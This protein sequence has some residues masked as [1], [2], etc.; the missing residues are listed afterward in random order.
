MGFEDN[1]GGTFEFPFVQMSQEDD[2]EN[3]VWDYEPLKKKRKRLSSRSH[4]SAR[5]TAD[6]VKTVQPADPQ[7][8]DS[9][10]CA[11]INGAGRQNDSQKESS[12]N[13]NGDEDAQDPSG[14]F[15]PIC[16]MPFCILVVQTPRWH[17][18]ECLEL[19]RDTCEGKDKTSALLLKIL[20]V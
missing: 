12:T 18:A 19:L 11:A 8:A 2:S 3:E 14:D 20:M 5:S 13:S 10:K 4:S 7:P 17:I 1:P 15:C 6:K 16:Q 9:R